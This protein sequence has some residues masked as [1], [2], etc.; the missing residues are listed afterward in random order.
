MTLRSR[1]RQH[2]A[3]LNPA[4]VFLQA[5]ESKRLP[6]DLDIYVGC[7]EEFFLAS[8]TLPAYIGDS[9]I[10]ILDDGNFGIVTFY[11]VTDGSLIQKDI[12]S[13]GEVIARFAHWQQYLAD[14]MIRIGE[15]VEDED[16]LRRIAQLIG[17]L[18]FPALMAFFDDCA[19][20]PRPSEY[21]GRRLRFIAG[22][23]K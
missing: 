13:P 4:P 21:E 12:E 16:Q 23:V 10:P 3:S 1:A 17:F 8:D 7:P 2:L 20:N 6:E 15:S 11:D 14:L 5:Y 18:H 19:D 22:I 9:L